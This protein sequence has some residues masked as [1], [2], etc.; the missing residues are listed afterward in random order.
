MRKIPVRTITFLTS[1]IVG[2]YL[3]DDKYNAR[4]LQRNGLTVWNGLCIGLDYKINF[5]PGKGD[6]IDDLHERVAQRILR[7]C[8][9]NGGLYI[10]LGQA[11]QVQSAILPP[12]Y[13]RTFKTMYDDAPAVD[14]DQ[15]QLVLLKFIVQNLKM[16][17]PLL[18]KFKNQILGNR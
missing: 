13:Q 6:K 14:F 2:I 3:I 15:L 8:K 5:R 18:L 9:S 7:V 11:T 12:A 4:T 10:K 1:T 16:E 17:P